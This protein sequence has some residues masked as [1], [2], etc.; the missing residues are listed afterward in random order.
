MTYTFPFDTCETPRSS[1]IAQP[2]SV[3]VNVIS[4]SIILLFLFQTKSN[5]AFLLLLALLIFELFHTLSHFIHIEGAFLYT[6]THITGFL[7]NV[8][9]F[10]FLY[11][12]TKVFPK[13][14]FVGFLCVI[15]ACDLYAFFNL[16]FIY[17]ILTQISLFISILF[18]YY[19]LL[20]QNIRTNLNVILATLFFIYFAFVNEKMNCKYM[21]QKF[22]NFPFHVII[23]AF[24]II[25]IYV[26]CNTFYC[27]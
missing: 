18:F 10:H 20:N 2:Y 23:E 4:C 19:P 1:G 15:L 5:H 25:P 27:L 21:L 12:Y 11:R 26:L 22:P 13:P 17:F 9:L 7:F 24:S 14:Y 3:F 6:A 8:A 16:S